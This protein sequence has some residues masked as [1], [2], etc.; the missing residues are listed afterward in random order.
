LI[1]S[2]A[3]RQRPALRPLF[4]AGSSS[5]IR[6]AEASVAALFSLSSYDRRHGV[7]M[8]ALRV[9]NDSSALMLCRIWA[10]APDGTPSLAYP[11]VFEIEPYSL[12]SVEV[13]IWPDK[14]M[15]AQHF[16]AEVAGGNLQCM[17]EARPPEI[18]GHS[19]PIGAIAATACLATGLGMAAVAALG[20]TFPRILAFAVPPVT[21]PG[22][23]VQVAYTAS[24]A[25]TLS[26]AVDGPNG[27]QIAAKTLQRQ[28]GLI[29][30][31]IPANAQAGAYTVQ[32]N[33]HGALGNAKELRVLNVAV[34]R[35]AGPRIGAISVSPVVAAPGQT[36]TATYTASASDG[37]VRLI[38]RDGTL[39][40]QKPFSRDGI[41]TFSL[42]PVSTNHE[43][44]VLLHVHRGRAFAESSAGLVVA[45]APAPRS[46]SNDGMPLLAGSDGASAISTP[47]D[48]A[49]GTFAVARTRVRS[50]DAIDVR[51]LS[52]RNAMR[53]ALADPQ[54]RE[55]ASADAGADAE[56]VTLRAP[57]VT[58]PSRYTVVATFTDGFGAET[59]VEPITIAPRR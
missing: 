8:Y 52:P 36:V 34:P 22:A 24:G 16:L 13:P 40:A 2:L 27:K 20:L 45:G 6:T 18:R 7:A 32:L 50:G 39:W 56:T 44:R 12:K 41:T 4:P 53:I 25:G 49:N 48:R 58:V 55:V 10:I 38:D 31:A 19:R 57:S 30:I 59:I 3:V 46:A 15:P 1:E 26:Y 21:Q 11:A 37:Y 54:S 47:D 29:P 51:I 43:M 42:P 23:T 5:A 28:S 35:N 9:A 14:R 33:L 17:V